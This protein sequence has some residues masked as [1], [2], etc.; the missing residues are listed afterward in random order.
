MTET[1]NRSRWSWLGSART[2]R[3]RIASGVGVAAV[4]SAAYFPTIVFDLGIGI[5][6][7]IFLPLSIPIAVLVDRIDK[8]AAQMALGKRPLKE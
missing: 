1:A 2:T 8:K 7:A 3:G 6:F 5:F 4:Y